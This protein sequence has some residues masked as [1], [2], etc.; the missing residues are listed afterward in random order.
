MAI[1]EWCIYSLSLVIDEIS[2]T[3]AWCISD[4]IIYPKEGSRTLIMLFLNPETD[5]S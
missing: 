4:N 1:E 5:A 3:S 2:S